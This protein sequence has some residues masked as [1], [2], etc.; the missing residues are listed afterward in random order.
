MA[1]E[2]V[3]C[4]RSRSGKR[5]Q[6]EKIG[7]CG[8]WVR[9]KH[10]KKNTRKREKKFIDRSQSGAQIRKTYFHKITILKWFLKSC[11]IL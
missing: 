9:I 3:N 1:R 4:A 5:R 2:K 6:G 10:Y 7:T 8:E 11:G